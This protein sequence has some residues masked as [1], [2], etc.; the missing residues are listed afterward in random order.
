[1]SYRFI[2]VE[3]ATYPIDV[4]CGVW[5]VARSGL[6]AWCRRPECA[7]QQEHQWRVTRIRASHRAARGHSGSLWIHRD[8]RVSVI[9]AN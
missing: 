8:R 6:C 4:L 3:K 2:Q 7:R 5:A 9:M 1:M